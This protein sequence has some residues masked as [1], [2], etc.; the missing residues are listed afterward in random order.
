MTKYNIGV[1]VPAILD[2]VKWYDK[3]IITYKFL[4]HILCLMNFFKSF[5]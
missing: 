5:L 1:V 2:H 3:F 4:L